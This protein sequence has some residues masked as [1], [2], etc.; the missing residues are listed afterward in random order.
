MSKSCVECADNYSFLVRCYQYGEKN[1]IC[2]KCLKA[3]I[4]NEENLENR[5]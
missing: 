5:F 2:I 3:K 4:K 1:W